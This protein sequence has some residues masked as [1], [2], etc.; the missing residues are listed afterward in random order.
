M[1][2]EVSPALRDLGLSSSVGFFQRCVSVRHHLTQRTTDAT[3]GAKPGWKISAAVKIV[4]NRSKLLE[5]QEQQLEKI[6]HL[7]RISLQW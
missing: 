1:S 4:E 5:Q 6:R 7:G 2:T 3:V